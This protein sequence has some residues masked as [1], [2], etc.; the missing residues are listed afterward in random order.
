[1]GGIDRGLDCPDCH[2]INHL[3]SC[4]QQSRG[5]NRR[6]SATRVVNVEEISEERDHKLGRPRQPNRD[7]S[8]DAKR[9]FASNEGAQKVVAGQIDSTASESDHF[10]CRKHDF[11]AENMV[12]SHAVLEAVRTAGILS[13]VAS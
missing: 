5:N 8:R 13:D 7:L 9:A 1:T 2:A 6:D 4:R 11:E 10:T 3:E 12:S